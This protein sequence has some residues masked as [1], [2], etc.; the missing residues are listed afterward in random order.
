MTQA[1]GDEVMRLVVA[2]FVAR[3]H[4]LG[5]LIADSAH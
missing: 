5:A 2:D 1:A 4:G 3:R